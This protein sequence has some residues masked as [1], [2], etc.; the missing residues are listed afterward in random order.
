[1]ATFTS[2]VVNQKP[3]RAAAQKD[4]IGEIFS[5][6][7]TFTIPGGTGA[8]DTCELTTVSVP[9]NC[10]ILDV[11]QKANAN[12][13]ANSAITMKTTT[14]GLV[15][16]GVAN[17]NNCTDGWVKQTMIP[18]N[19]VST[20]DQTLTVVCSGANGVNSANVTVQINMLLMSTGAGAN[21][22]ATYTI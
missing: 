17:A 10:R 15:F 19:A 14:D 16:Y 12:G 4:T 22:L 13:A 20:V 9:A 7:F 2:T 11:Y 8:N 3:A 6:N 18:A 5:K 1:M 21:G